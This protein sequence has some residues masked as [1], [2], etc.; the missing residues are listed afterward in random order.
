MISAVVLSAGKGTRMNSAVAKQYLE[1]NGKPVIYYA[2]KAFEDSIVDEIVLVAGKE[3]I[4]YVEK[5]IVKANGFRKVRAVVEGGEY[6]FS[7]VY[8]GLKAADPETE[9]VFIHDGAR[10]FV[11]A[12]MIE[13]LYSAVKEKK[14]AVAAC[15]VKDTIKI[16]DDEGRV[17]Q[18]PQRSSLWQV[19]TP[20]AFSYGLAK[21]A[22]DKLM[23]AGDRNVTDDAMVVETYGKNPVYLV[24]TG[25]TNIKVTT[26]ED[27]VI[28]EAFMKMKQ[29]FFR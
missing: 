9:Y 15:P 24:N 19:Q 10:P 22:Y 25:Y 1:L 23:A 4:E 12:E 17:V 13:K 18:T 6:R 16:T 20:Q 7:S 14:T 21:A 28:A 3:D 8:N 27:M 29:D 2:L 26:P 5:K 11:S